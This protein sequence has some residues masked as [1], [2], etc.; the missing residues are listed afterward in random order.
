MALLLACSWAE[1]LAWREAY[2]GWH[3][4]VTARQLLGVDYTVR[5]H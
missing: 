2:V 1:I 3:C 4:R 5:Y